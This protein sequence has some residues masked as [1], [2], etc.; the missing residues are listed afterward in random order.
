RFREG[1]AA[2]SGVVALFAELECDRPGARAESVEYL[3]PR[4]G[5]RRAASV[6]VIAS[7]LRF[8]PALLQFILLP[9]RAPVLRR[10]LFR[11]PR[12]RE[13]RA[14]LPARARH[15]GAAL[16]RLLQRP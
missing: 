9:Q 15:G 6:S 16:L 1:E 2:A 10:D 3:R 5:G 4:R 14:V 11:S 7:A 13:R 12:L 8:P